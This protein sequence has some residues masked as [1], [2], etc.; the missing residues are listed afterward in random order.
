MDENIIFPQPV[1]R[2]R[3]Q[4]LKSDPAEI[5]IRKSAAGRA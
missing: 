2:E 5:Q 1:G 4:E 3:I